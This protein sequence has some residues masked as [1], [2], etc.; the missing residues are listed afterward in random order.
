MA[1]QHPDHAQTPYWHSSP[2]IRTQDEVYE[3]FHTFADLGVHEYKWDWEG[4]FVDESVVERLLSENFAF[5]QK[6]PLGKERF[7]TFRLPNPKVETE[8][9]LGRALFAVLTAAG[10]AKQVD[11]HSPPLFEVILPMAET[12]EELIAVQNAFDELTTLKHPLLKFESDELRQIQIIPLFEQVSVIMDSDSIVEAYISH[13]TKKYGK[14]PEYVRPY[15]ARSDPTLNSG[16]IATVLAIKIALSRYAKLEK[17]TGVAQY[18]I[19]GAAALPFRGGLTPETVSS[20]AQEYAGIRTT[21]L[22]SAFRYDYPLS[23]V[24]KA[25]QQLDKLLPSFQALVLSAEDESRLRSIIQMAEQYYQRSVEHIAPLVNTLA[26]YVPKR[27]ERVQH[28]GLFGYSRGVGSV[29]LPRA[30]KFTGSLYS[31]GVP[32]EIIGTGRTLRTLQER[33]EVQLL[34]KFYLNLRTDLLRVC[35]Y[36]NKETIAILA[37]RYPEWEEIQIDVQEIE[38]YLGEPCTPHTKEEKEHAD[39]AGIIF[40]LVEKNA[41]LDIISDL[42]EKTAVLRKSIG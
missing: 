6:Y 35:R 27:R 3:C 33:G 38:S 15:V 26:A 14:K 7:L 24:R 36:V 31:I 29:T 16:N 8:F 11:L 4:K 1:S 9:R 34:E 39:I 18:P 30:I 32:P 20:F 40:Q 37:K 19:I 13:G 42:I 12:A 41:S 28:I 23:Q 22:Q 25:I 21:L 17:K 2:Y 10:L 5:F